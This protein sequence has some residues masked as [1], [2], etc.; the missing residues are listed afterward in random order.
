M[1]VK[2]LAALFLGMLLAACSGS[3]ST[4]SRTT[5]GPSVTEQTPGPQETSAAQ[6]RSADQETSTTQATAAIE[7]TSAAGDASQPIEPA[8]PYDLTGIWKG[9]LS[10]VGSTG[11]CPAT[12]PQQGTVLIEQIGTVF[13]MLFDEGFECAPAG[14]CEFAGTVDDEEYLCS[15]TGVADSEGGLYSSAILMYPSD[16]DHV[17]G[18]GASSYVHP[19]IECTWETSLVLVRSDE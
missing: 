6:E 8:T 2:L 13:T 16:A 9:Q 14:A 17:T 5:E 11:P 18:S 4:E 7:E 3:G 10:G 1:L 15:N 12:P 19:E